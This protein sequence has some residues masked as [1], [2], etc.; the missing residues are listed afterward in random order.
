MNIR[1]I[2]LLVLTST[3]GLA[4]AAAA[5]SDEQA[6]A[7]FQS[8]DQDGN[9]SLNRAELPSFI[10]AMAALGHAESQRAVRFGRI[11]YNTAWRRADQDKN[12]A[13]T[14]EELRQIR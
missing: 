9:G 2:T 8:A 1:S 4:Q 3:I 14:L 11:G 13:V 7:A 10:D 5:Q 12:G 6:T